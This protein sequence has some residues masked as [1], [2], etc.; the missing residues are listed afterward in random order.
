MNNSNLVPPKFNE[1]KYSSS[2]EQFVGSKLYEY[3]VKNDWIY[4]FQTHT[5]RHQN[6]GGSIHGGILMTAIDHILAMHILRQVNPP[7]R[8]ATIQLNSYF[9]SRGIAG[10][11]VIARPKIIR[12]TRD[13]IFVEGSLLHGNNEFYFARGIWKI[14]QAT[15]K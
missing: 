13:V 12:R 3:E 7:S 14:V 4:G 5:A 9:V 10:K 6:Q 1:S 15:R 2:F 11:F 8:I